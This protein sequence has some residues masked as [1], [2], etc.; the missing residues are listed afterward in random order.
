LRLG[1]IRSATKKILDGV[2][3]TNGSDIYGITPAGAVERMTP[4]GDW[5]FQP[6][7]PADAVYPQMD[8]SI[9]IA[10]AGLP[11]RLWTIR[12]P[13]DQILD[14]TTLSAIT[15]GPRAQ[16]GDRL[17][18]TSRDGLAG[19]RGRD[20]SPLKK[21]KLSSDARAI[22]ATPSG[23]RLYIAMAETPRIAI[24][25]RYRE[26]VVGTIELPS[27]ASDL[28]IDPLGQSLLARP[29]NGADSVW[30]IAIGTGKQIGSV[31]SEWT[32]DLPAFAPLRTIATLRGGDVVFVDATTLSTK[33]TITGGAKDYWYFF[34]WDG[35]RPRAASLDQPVTFDTAPK[36]SADTAG[37]PTPDSTAARPPRRDTSSAPVRP[38]PPAA[39]PPSRPSGFIVSFAAV[40]NEQRANEIAATIQIGGAQAR[41]I[42]TQSSGTNIYRVVLGPYATREEAERVGKDSRRAYWVY[43]GGT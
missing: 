28:R 27:P 3:S 23:D 24:V 9:V 13:D 20:L 19:V 30:V 10:S 1:E 17:Y 39:P 31:A 21:I 26:S 43:E 35:F 25:D 18:F 41:V 42:Q 29:A 40:L 38:A 11:T 8:G 14:S 34:S 37:A 15:R 2:T 12:P 4:S 5:T 32:R 22:E 16:A 33:Q 36:P 6:P 7:K